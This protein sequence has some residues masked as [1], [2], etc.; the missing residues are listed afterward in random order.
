MRYGPRE[1]IS[2][3]AEIKRTN[4]FAYFV[5]ILR[6]GLDLA[7]LLVSELVEDLPVFDLFLVICASQTQ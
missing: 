2:K 1:C 5:C 4:L 7:Q 3:W 6:Q